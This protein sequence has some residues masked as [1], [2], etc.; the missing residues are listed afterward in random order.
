MR[1]QDV[2]VMQKNTKKDK[3]MQLLVMRKLQEKLNWGKVMQ[4]LVM[5]TLQAELNWIVP[6]LTVKKVQP[7]RDRV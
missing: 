7:K 1:R 2:Y 3:V 5:R 6:I 4:L